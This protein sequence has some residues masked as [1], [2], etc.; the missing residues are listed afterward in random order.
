MEA[1]ISAPFFIVGAHRSGS[2]LLRTMLD[3]HPEL[4]I[5]HEFEFAMHLVGKNGEP[6]ELETFYEH[7]A[8]NDSF[9]R[10]GF[11]IDRALDFKALINS[12]LERGRYGKN[13][14]G[15]TCHENFDRLQYFWPDSRYIHLVRDPRDVANSAVQL[16]WAGNT[17]E[18]AARWVKAERMWEVLRDRI[19]ED[20]RIE[21]SFENLM[22][23]YRAELV[24]ICEFL[25]V[26]FDEQML[27][28]PDDSDFKLPSPGAAERW[29]KSSS[30]RSVQLVEARV[31]D[32]LEMR[33][34]KPSGLPKLEPNSLERSW[35]QFDS[36]VRRFWRSSQ[37][38]GLG[39]RTSVMLAQRLGRKEWQKRLAQERQAIIN[40]TIQKPRYDR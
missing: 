9:S 16:S 17:W 20:R 5:P 39:H 33:G 7:L 35:L 40:S 23:D 26:E 31:G 18:A 25:G 4:S 29:R 19:P 30:P 15:M 3:H 13:Q 34:Y 12:F 22:R 8:L 24:R 21:L 14:V 27:S 10:S 37:Q 32:L 6:P 38:F 28:Y 11:E 1:Q 2:T 36:R